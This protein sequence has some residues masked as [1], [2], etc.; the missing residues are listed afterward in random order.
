[1]GVVVITRLNNRGGGE[2]DGVRKTG[3]AAVHG[4]YTLAARTRVRAAAAVAA[5]NSGTIGTYLV[6]PVYNDQCTC[7]V[8]GGGT[9]A[10]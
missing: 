4:R 5:A 10:D 8:G 6:L 7:T 1:M 3:T 2:T 9:L